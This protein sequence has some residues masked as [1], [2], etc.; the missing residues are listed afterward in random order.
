MST[1][2]P[3]TPVAPKAVTPEDVALILHTSGTTSRPKIVPLLQSNLVAS[4]LNIKSALALTPSDRCMN[5]MPLFHIHGLMAPVLANL[6]SGASVYCTP[7]FDALRFFG[8]LTDAQPSWYSAVPTMHQAILSRA[9]RNADAVK[10]ASL[11]YSTN[12]SLVVSVS[13]GS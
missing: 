12:S 5:V 9:P 1:D 7:G 6:T 11:K 13:T 2:T 8:W 4:A 10:N 3:V